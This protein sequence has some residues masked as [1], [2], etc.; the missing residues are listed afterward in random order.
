MLRKALTTKEATANHAGVPPS[1]FLCMVAYGPHEQKVD[2]AGKT[3]EYVRQQ[4]QHIFNIPP[5]A[6]PVVNRDTV[7]DEA[8]EAAYVIP[9]GARIVFLPTI[10]FKGLGELLT[11]RQLKKRWK[12]TEAQYKEL[13]GKGLPTIELSGEVRHP[14]EAVDE[15]FRRMGWAVEG[16]EI[17]PTLPPHSAVTSQRSVESGQWVHDPIDDPPQEYK[18]GRLEG[19]RNH[20]SSWLR[21]GADYRE[22]DRRANNGSVWV[23]RHS[24]THWEAFFR[25]K[26]LYEF[27]KANSLTQ[28][29]NSTK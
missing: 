14:E 26:A 9:P 28:P 6:L 25:D 22:L 1:A 4:L 21:P 8:A 5:D 11:P 23:R 17:R 18:E 10:G 29:P 24:R 19:T 16:T 27:A 3:V 2:V 7:S 12:I 20:L 13:L 15:W